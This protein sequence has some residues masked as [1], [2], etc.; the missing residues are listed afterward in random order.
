MIYH[1]LLETDIGIK[2][3]KVDDVL[4]LDLLVAGVAS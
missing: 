2:T 3:G 4:A 1:F